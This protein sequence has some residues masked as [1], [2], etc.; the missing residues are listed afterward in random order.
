MSILLPC[1]D[2][3]A[4]LHECIASLEAQTFTDYEVIAVDD[5]SSDATGA[6]L[7]DWSA[8]D[9]RVRVAHTAPAG[10]VCALHAA[11]EQARGEVIAR[12]DADDVAH[13]ERLQAQLACMAEHELAACAA[14]VEYFPRENLSD[15]ALAYEQWV[16]SLVTPED[17]ARDVFVECPLPHP[18]LMVRSDVLER[19]G[20]YRETGWPEDYDLVLR[21]WA[22]GLRLGKVARPL[23]R[24]RNGDARLSRTDVRYG[25]AA[26]RACRVAFLESTLLRARQHL[27]ICGAGPVGKAFA[28]D[29]LA[30]GHTLRAF[31]DLDERKIGQVIHGAPV[32]PYA[33]LGEPAGCFALAAVAGRRARTEI[34]RALTQ[35]GWIEMRDF[36]AVA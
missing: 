4:H 32:L 23:L 36:C 17:I 13:P 5:G 20:G 6:I 33:A 30:R 19:I 14:Q 7:H 8:R 15:G 1:R 27:V 25:Q 9:D 29:L 18:T 34:R 2:A 24:W 26:F 11:V 21:L 3:A 16:N 12:M 31:V 10:I 22:A 28:R 35:R